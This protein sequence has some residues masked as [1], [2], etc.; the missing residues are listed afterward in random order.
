MRLYQIYF[1]PTGG[2]KK[3]A[4]LLCS[5]WDCEPEE[6]DL[7]SPEEE[8]ADLALT[9]EDICIVAVPSYGGRVPEIARQ[10]LLSIKGGGARAVLAVV[11]GNRAFEDTLLELRDV[12]EIAGFRCAAATAAVAEHSIARQFAAGRPDEEDRKELQGFSENI[13][14]YLAQESDPAQV[15]VPGSKPYRPYSSIPLKPSAGRSCTGCGLC[16]RKCPAKAI[17]EGQPKR[18]DNKTCISCMRCVSVCP[19]N[20]RHL[21]KLM[22]HIASTK[23]KKV[24]SQR[25]EN[26]L[27]LS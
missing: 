19:K 21:N 9:K 25:Q 18:T 7:C 20:A 23:L 13:R 10:H 11:Y 16:A 26:Q 27:Y 17:P 14:M 5:A 24:C 4:Q 6:I 8:Y 1:S 3:V 2:V 22:L 15:R 12:L